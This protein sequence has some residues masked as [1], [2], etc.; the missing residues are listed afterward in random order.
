MKTY[1]CILRMHCINNYLHAPFQGYSEFP[2]VQLISS[3]NLPSYFGSPPGQVTKLYYYCW[4]I[5]PSP[6]NYVFWF[7]NCSTSYPQNLSVL[8]LLHSAQSYLSVWEVL[9]WATEDSTNQY[10]SISQMLLISVWRIAGA[11]NN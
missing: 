9:S 2:W 6:Q 11:T 3:A 8:G 7:W 10:N 5:L 4:F 1:F